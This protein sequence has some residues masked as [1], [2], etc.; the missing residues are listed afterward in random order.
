MKRVVE[1]P[2]GMLLMSGPT[3]SG[4]TTTLYSLLHYIN[5]DERHI[6]T[7]EEPVE[8]SVKGFTQIE[9]NKHMGWLSAIASSLRLDPDVIMIGEIRDD[10]GNSGE[11]SQSAD[12]AFRAGETGH[13]VLS[14]VHANNAITTIMRLLKLGV[15]ATTVA[16]TLKAV[17]AQR[18]VPKFVEGAS[19]TWEEPTQVEVEW[20]KRYNAYAEGIRLPH[21]VD[22]EFS[23]RLPV[24]EMIEI[25]QEMKTVLNEKREDNWEVRLGELAARQHQFETLAQ[26]GVRLVLAGLT[27]LDEIIKIT[28]DVSH[29]PKFKRFEQVLVQKGIITGKDIDEG[30]L[31]IDTARAQGRIVELD[32]YFINAGLCNKEQIESAMEA[33]HA[34]EKS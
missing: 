24:I 23:G 21:S 7:I 19:L 27:T 15:P 34:T 3:G 9:V 29:V 30:Y 12:A 18:L 13:F 17:V 22:G 2:E 5:D 14:T 25:D 16:R 6:L 28:S 26:A 8:Y 33:S 11:T 32:A 20:L 1:S 31:A 4:K 10:N